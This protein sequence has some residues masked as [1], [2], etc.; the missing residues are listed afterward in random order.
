MSHRPLL[1][2]TEAGIYCRPG[3]FLIDPWQ[4]VDR[5]IITHAH[6]DHARPGCR[7]YLASFDGEGILRL[8]LGPDIR[9]QSV[10][11]GEKVTLNGV[12]VS[13]HPAGHVLGSAQIRIEH[14]GE[15]WVVSGDYK[16]ETDAT[17]R[18]FEQLKC[19]TFVTESTFGLPVFKWRPQAD[20]FADI[21]N[22][23][24]TN[25][26]QG[27]TSVLFAYSLGKAQRVIAG[28][29]AT[30]GPIFTHGAVENINQC[31]QEAGILLPATRHVA[32]VDDKNAFAGA[33]AVAP[34][35]ADTPAYTKRFANASKAFASGW[36][37]IRGMRRRRAVDRGFVLSDHSDW[38]GLIDTIKASEAENI[39]VTHGYSA[40]VVQY[41]QEQGLN[42]R[43]IETQFSSGID[44][45]EA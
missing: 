35:S 6:A 4:A 44:R 19:H 1:E 12:T 40:E 21:N 15:V 33:M 2:M 23:W 24:K 25:Q 11:Y 32:T 36:M 34:P 30:I 41:L 42:A 38:S 8:R 9:L 17:C 13:L 7:Q 27:K 20:I 26:A 3:D 18:A 22:W 10:D 39:W 14:K 29:D 5:A 31:Y 43:Q 45:T 37:Q 16:V 28:L